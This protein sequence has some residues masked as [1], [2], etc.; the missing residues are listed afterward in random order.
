MIEYCDDICAQDSIMEFDKDEQAWYEIG[1][2]KK[3]RAYSRDRFIKNKLWGPRKVHKE[4]VTGASTTIL[5]IEPIFICVSS[6][7]RWGLV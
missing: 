1:K 2:M 6:S 7:Q 3:S 5:K 4:A